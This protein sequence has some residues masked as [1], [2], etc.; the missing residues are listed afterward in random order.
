MT[1][2]TTDTFAGARGTVATVDWPLE[3]ARRAV[4]IAHGYGEHIGRYEH[5]AARLTQ[6]GYVV[7][8]LDHHG[9][10][11][12]AG[13]RGKVSLRVAVSDLDQLIVTIAKQRHPELPQFLLG[14]SMGGCI[15]LCYSM[16]HQDRLHGLLLS[17]PLAALD[18][19]PAPV[20]LV[21]RV[22]SAVAPRLPV[23]AVDA[24]LVSRDPAVVHD[25]ETDPLVH[26]G[27]LP[28]RTVAELAAAVESF[29]SG[30][31]VITIPTLIMYGTADRLAP[32][33]GSVM[34]GERIGAADKTVT[35]Y[36]GLFHEIL[37]EPERE[38]VMDDMCSWL[39]AHVGVAATG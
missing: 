21:A 8:G 27:K 5:V 23:F 2:R 32:P 28:V 39:N 33:A 9:H 24:T 34:L 13:K 7:Y 36:D 1:A 38:R 11:Q 37:N 3:D 22:L 29:P 15:A 25:Y 6:A 17:G 35:P 31:G 20:R 14:H 16:R 26:H 10:G 12:S 30:V 18:A 4:V 19:A